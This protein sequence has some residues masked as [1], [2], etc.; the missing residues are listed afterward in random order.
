M[1]FLW[2]RLAEEAFIGPTIKLEI[3]DEHAASKAD[4][5]LKRRCA[6]RIRLQKGREDHFGYGPD[7]VAWAN[8]GTLEHYADLLKRMT[9]I[10]FNEGEH[11]A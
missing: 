5:Q 9:E 7:E 2:L 1:I 3:E 11:A 8:V 10:A 4:H 6:G